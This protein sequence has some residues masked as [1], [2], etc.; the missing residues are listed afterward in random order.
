MHA[1]KIVPLIE[2]IL[3]DSKPDLIAVTAGPGLITGLLVGTEAARAL[4]YAWKIP[5]VAVNHLEGHFYSVE[6]DKQP[7]QYPALAL[8]VSGG[9]SELV[10]S[11]KPGHYRRLGATRDDAA[12]ECFDKVA[13]MLGLPYPG[14]PEISRLAQTGRT[15][16]IHFPRPMIREENLDF[17]FAGLKTAALYWLKDN[18]LN[19]KISLNDFCASL[20]QAIVDVLVAKTVQAAKKTKPQT[21]ILS[22]GVSANHKLRATLE[23]AVEKNLPKTKFRTPEI[24]YCMD[25]ASMIAVA[26]YHQATKKKTT[27]WQKMMANPNAQLG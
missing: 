20:E 5:L 18:T 22:G 23:T 6:T 13:K 21:I 1:E 7:I 8:I 3:G 9:H 19:Q 26:G 27:P 16:A 2:E 15:D 11:K 24:K 4:S 25:N 14:G 17:S 10:F 12:G